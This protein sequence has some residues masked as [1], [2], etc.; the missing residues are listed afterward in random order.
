MRFIDKALLKARS[1]EPRKKKE[2]ERPTAGPSV[3]DIPPSLSGFKLHP[4]EIRYTFTKTMPVDLETMRLSRLISG[5][6][7]EE[8]VLEEYKHLRTQILSRTKGEQKNTLMITGPLPGEGKT[9]TA[10]NLAISL[11][12]EVDKTVLLVDADLRY[13]SVHSYFGL[14]PGPGLVDYLT[15]SLPLSELLVHPGGLDKLVILPG[16]RAVSQ[17]AEL[18]SSPLMADLTQELKHFYPDRYVLFDTP[19]VLSYADPL[20]FAPLVDGIILVVEKGRT[21]REDLLKCVEL[22]KPYPVLGTVLNK[23]ESSNSRYKYYKYYGDKKG[24]ATPTPSKRQGE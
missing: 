21:P 9:L 4:G 2:Q 8:G 1:S 3:A 14:P 13:P 15:N 16:G 12:Q 7:E 22:L 24:A 20:A 17:A 18:L 23:V 10:I 5:Q 6:Q 11:A 19:P